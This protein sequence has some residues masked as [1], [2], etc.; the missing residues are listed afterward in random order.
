MKLQLQHFSHLMQRTDSLEKTLILEKTEGKRTSEWQSMKLFDS[1]T[2][3]MGKN[4]SKFLQS[5]GLQRVRYKFTSEQKQQHISFM[6]IHC[7]NLR[8]HFFSGF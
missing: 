3:S 7:L 6:L 4:L 5:V 1:I 2:D 8:R